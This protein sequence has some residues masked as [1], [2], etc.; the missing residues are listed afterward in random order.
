MSIK[1]EISNELAE[2]YEKRGDYEKAR[3]HYFK[4]IELGYEPAIKNLEHFYV[5]EIRKTMA[6][7]EDDNFEKKMFEIRES[8]IAGAGLGVFA[9]KKI[10]QNMSLGYYKG[11]VYTDDEFKKVPYTLYDFMFKLSAGYEKESKQI[12][13]HIDAS[14]KNKSNWTRYVNGAKNKEQEKMINIEVVTV[15]VSLAFHSTKDIEPG[16]ELIISYGE[17]YWKT[18]EERKN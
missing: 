15:G 8:T 7:R 6:S 17:T 11:E 10:A 2:M 14:D 1:G 9:K 5:S 16:T 18:I 12:I 4:S 3:E 13:L